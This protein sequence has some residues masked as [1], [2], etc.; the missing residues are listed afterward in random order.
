[1]MKTG[2]YIVLAVAV[3]SLLVAGCRKNQHFLTDKTYRDQVHADFLK[4]Q[5]M[6]QGRADQLF[7]CMDTLDTETREAMEFLYAYMPIAT[8]PT[9]MVPSS[10]RKCVPP[11][12]PATL[13]RG[14]GRCPKIFSAILCSSTVSTTKTSTRHAC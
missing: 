12:Q 14:A 5:D 6:A 3:F 1:M 7:A 13:L 10:C 2:R 4:R 11:F 8:L 9:T